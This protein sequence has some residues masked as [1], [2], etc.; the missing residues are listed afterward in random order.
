MS[1]AA[2]TPVTAQPSPDTTSMI[3][4]LDALYARRAQP[5]PMDELIRLGEQSLASDPDSY[6]VTWR[7][8][9]ARWWTCH[10][11]EDKDAGRA[12][13]ERAREDAE[14]A[15]RL[16]PHGVE[17][18]LMHAFAIGDYATRIGILRAV[19]EGIGSR[20]ENAI[21]EA[22]E[23]DRDYDHG[24]GIVAFGRF[25]Y[26]L[27]WP[28]RD[29]EKSRRLLEEAKQRHPR[30][31]LG[32]LYLADTYRALDQ[33][34]AARGELEAVIASEPLPQ[35]APEDAP[36]ASEARRRMRDWFGDQEPSP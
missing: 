12:A 32:R 24:A 25:Y 3:E 27:P 9:R 34:E 6:D 19:R 10:V 29:L 11:S 36:A 4:Q 22:Y 2:A 16:R 30:T 5:G 20:F 26:E 17:A 33:D 15:I 28:M 13:C 31:L 23:L 18:R 14:R 1:L 35:R 8:A 21:R 7:I